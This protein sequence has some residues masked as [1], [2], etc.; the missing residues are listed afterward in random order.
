MTKIWLIKAD[1]FSVRR[2]VDLK[3]D[4]L[5]LAYIASYIKKYGGFNDVA[6]SNEGRGLKVDNIKK[7]NPDIVGVSSITQNFD[8]ARDL[9]KKIKEIMDIPV[10]VGGYHISALPQNLDSNMTA[11][12]LGEGELTFLELLLSYE[13]YGLTFKRLSKINGVAYQN[14]RALKITPKR[15]PIRPLD[16][17]PFPNRNLLDIS[18]GNFY[19]FTSRG[20]PYSCVF[21]ASTKFWGCVR[22]FSP[23]Y[24][25]REILEIVNKYKPK[26]IDFCDDLF[27]SDRKRVFKITSLLKRLD[28]GVTFTCAARANLIDYRLALALKHA[29]FR[30]V[31]MGLESGSPTV[32]KYLKGDSVTVN[33][34]TKAI[35]ILKNVGLS[36]GASFVI[37]S[38]EETENQCFE[39]LDFVKR[40][41]ID[42]GST[43][44]LLPFPNTKLWDECERLGLVSDSMD[45][46]KFK[47]NYDSDSK[48]RLI[49]SKHISRE[50]LTK[51]DLMFKTE[52][53]KRSRVYSVF[54]C[55]RHL[56]RAAFLVYDIF[57]TKKR[58]L[59][60]IKTEG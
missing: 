2:R 31:S 22:F 41:K 38:L 32:L 35:N 9:A 13:S 34:N 30:R 48:D 42:V 18:S 33:Q 20:C 14:N 7:V 59:G 50:R 53:K 44:V 36:V 43:F 23:E 47:M 10:I 3:Y 46:S 54:Y 29:N 17:I 57:K 45:W 12:V 26:H 24:V 4:G 25:I 16:N 39:T 1:D 6:I 49:V 37:G 56:D 8:V 28:L 19:M 15:K 52:W 55:L 60:A 40:S 51:I 58:M 11:A 21:C 27:I 5:G